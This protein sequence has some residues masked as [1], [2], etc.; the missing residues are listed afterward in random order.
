MS[1]FAVCAPGLE[2]ALAEELEELLGRP[3]HIE[4]GGVHAE[5]DLVDAAGL[6]LWSRCAA[7]I[8]FVLGEVHAA[9]LQQ[10][11][12]EVRKLDWSDIIH[13][14]QKVEIKVAGRGR[15][16]HHAAVA[17]KVGLAVGDSLR[18]S[19]QQARSPGRGKG[20][21][22]GS[23]KGPKRGS[24][25]PKRYGSARGPR[26]HHPAI[27]LQVRLDERVA[28]LSL[29]AGGL[30][31]KRGYRQAT[32][33]A[34]IRENLA[35]CILRMAGWRPGVP[36]VDPMCGAGTF[37][38]EAAM[39]SA[40][41]APGTTPPPVSGLP[42]FPD[43]AWKT[44]FD[45]ATSAQRDA[46]DLPIWT[47][48]RDRGACRATQDNAGRAGVHIA[49]ACKDISAAFEPSPQG[50]GLVVLNPPYGIRVADNVKLAPLYHKIGGALRTQF[51]GWRVV[52]VCPDKA[53][54]GRVA[55]MEELVRFKNGGISV[56][57]F[58]G[59]L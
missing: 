49:P 39:W 30:L 58:V 1:I 6:C 14:G 29:D 31:H 10:L 7:R 37:S 26:G 38:I 21:K 4:R 33:K 44:M 48:D 28:R 57:V 3:V 19:A 27:T 50:P 53:L 42:G 36:L 52:M 8:L 16:K 43:G 11:E 56:G 24:V 34:P 9:S 41:L 45:E 40:D 2:P 23:K 13:P 17:K 32:A 47:A 25:A 35:A 20:P 12:Q 54:A 15:I 46:S 18:A 59:A 22:R 51:P 55:K 5:G